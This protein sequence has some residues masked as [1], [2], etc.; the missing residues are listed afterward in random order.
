[1][2]E[3]FR[4]DEVFRQRS[5]VERA[6]RSVARGPSLWSIRAASSLP[7]P[8]SPST[9]AANGAAAAFSID[10]RTSAIAGL[11]PSSSDVRDCRS[12]D[13][14]GHHGRKRRPCGGR[15]GR[16]QDRNVGSSQV[17]AA[18]HVATSTPTTC[19]AYRTGTPAS[20][21][22][23]PCV[24]APAGWRSRSAA[25]SPARA[26]R[27]RRHTDDLGPS[28]P[29]NAT[30]AAAAG[31]GAGRRPRP[32]P[33]CPPP[34]PDSTASARRCRPPRR[35]A[36]CVEDGRSGAN[37][38]RANSPVASARRSAASVGSA[39]L[40][41]S[42]S[43]S[44]SRPHRGRQR[45]RLDLVHPPHQ[46]RC[47]PALPLAAGNFGPQHTAAEASIG[48]CAR[49]AAPDR[50][51]RRRITPAC[52]RPR[53]AARARTHTTRRRTARGR[54]AAPRHRGPERHRP[55]PPPHDR[56]QPRPAARHAQTDRVARQIVCLG[57]DE[58]K[59]LKRLGVASLPVQAAS[60]RERRLHAS[61]P[62]PALAADAILSR[63]P[64]RL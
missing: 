38:R 50:E 12:A 15:S 21:R 14:S 48:S 29:K 39:A 23:P 31:H 42:R 58:R 43:R 64:P 46:Q 28:S 40:S 26:L 57:C 3:Q 34:R 47:R 54:R 61:R 8:L 6:E 45:G 9:S 2:T 53:R 35:A 25:H 22:S 17:D 20:T 1:M 19:P 36:H 16:E 55:P 27:H 60:H 4:F 13:A 7:E 32:A 37:R 5:A 18:V 52:C 41:A 63:A 30:P 24:A 59:P 49:R 62:V 44:I 33:R 11:T 51:R 10:G 56:D